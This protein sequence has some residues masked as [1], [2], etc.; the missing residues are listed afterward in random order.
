MKPNYFSIH[1]RNI[2][3]IR[4]HLYLIDLS[5]H[6]QFFFLHDKEMKKKFVDREGV[7]T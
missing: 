4:I 5:H 1:V 2:I 3:E 7:F 6:G